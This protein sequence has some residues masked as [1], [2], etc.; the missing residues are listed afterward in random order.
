MLSAVLIIMI[1]TTRLMPLWAN[2]ICTIL[3]GIRFTWRSMLTIG[4]FMKSESHEGEYNPE[5][6]A[7]IEKND[8]I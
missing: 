6:V 8:I 7:K 5:T 1:W 2:I 4:R 3:L